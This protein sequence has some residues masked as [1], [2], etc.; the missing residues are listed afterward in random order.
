MQ[1]GAN[2]N[3]K[4]TNYNQMNNNNKIP[5]NK[6]NDFRNQQKQGSNNDEH[7]NNLNKLKICM[8]AN[9]RNINQRLN[10]N[11]NNNNSNVY[12]N[13]QVKQQHQS[14]NENKQVTTNNNNNNNNSTSTASTTSTNT[15]T[16]NNN[17]NNGNFNQN[18][19]QNNKQLIVI[20]TAENSVTDKKKVETS[21]KR[22]SSATSNECEPAKKLCQGADEKANENE[23]SNNN[24][25]K[26]LLKLETASFSNC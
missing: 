16:T 18:R 19:F 20:K 6:M 7:Q 8:E 14:Q 9:R 15:S 2:A 12:T 22:P 26:S 5:M 4:V 17:N 23:H 10:V 11:N 21:L 24:K 1:H 3:N 25:G 13:N